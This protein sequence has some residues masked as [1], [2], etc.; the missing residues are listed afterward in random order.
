MILKLLIFL[1][2]VFF[3]YDIIII[4]KLKF[5]NLLKESFFG[6]NYQKCKIGNI[7]NIAKK[8]PIYLDS[9]EIIKDFPIAYQTYGKLNAAKNNAILICHALTGDQYVASRN[10]VTQKNGWW[11]H[12]VGEGKAIDTNKFFII[13]INSLGSCMGSFGPKE[14]NTETNTPYNL[15]FPI[16]TIEDMVKVQK[17]FIEEV[18]ALKKLYSVIGGSMGGMQALEW[19]SSYPEMIKSAIILA[20]SARH[21]A[22]NIAFHEVGRQAIMADYNWYKGEYI[23]KK[24]FPEKGLAVARM[25][26]HVTYLSENAL[27]EKFGRNLQEKKNFTYNFDIDFQIESYLHHQ[28]INFVDRF[29]P[30]SYLYITKAM[31][32]FDLGSKHGSLE[33][34][35]QKAANIKFCLISFSDDWLFPTSESRFI[36][37]AL[38]NIGAEVSFA[39][40]K[41]TRGHDS[42]LVPNKQLDDLM[43]NFILGLNDK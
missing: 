25:A 18:F 29:D 23:A 37:R 36:L 39:E 33:L 1:C 15:S 17:Q 22:Q 8:K 16:I 32:Y 6:K 28:G 26:A 12:V 2:L 27:A 21:T 43:E 24:S 19:S 10:P 35:F 30:N 9:G 31:D 38:N 40:I 41:S 4:N 3:I 7:V 20:S 34:A 13:S 5:I 14:I 42:F 11:D